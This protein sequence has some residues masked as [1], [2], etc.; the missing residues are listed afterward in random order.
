MLSYLRRKLSD[1][2]A[3]INNSPTNASAAR[4]VGSQSMFDSLASPALLTEVEIAEDSLLHELGY[5]SATDLQETV[6][7]TI[8]SYYP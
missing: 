5:R 2:D 8:I 6:Y 3:K 7:G 4:R 1:S